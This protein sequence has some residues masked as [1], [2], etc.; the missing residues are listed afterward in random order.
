MN[1]A[2]FRQQ[3][4][5][6]DSVPDAEL[7]GALYEKF[8]AGKLPRDDFDAQ[9]L[10]AS[11]PASDPQP[12]PQQ[13]EPDTFLSRSADGLKRMYGDLVGDNPGQDFVT[14]LKAAVSG[15]PFVGQYVD[16]AYAAARSAVTG[17]DEKQVR[18]A[19]NAPVEQM[20]PYARAGS[21]VAGGLATPM[22]PGVGGAITS[23]AT[24]P[25]WTVPVIAAIESIF[26]GPGRRD[27]G[28]P[29]AQD[30]AEN[31]IPD[32]V[33]GATGGVG[34]LALSEVMG[35]TI[36]A[37]ANAFRAARGKPVDPFVGKGA[38]QAHSRM[39]AAVEANDPVLT[40]R[41]LLEQ[42]A[43]AS[44][45]KEVFG[46]GGP[47]AKQVSD[48][49][50]AVMKDNTRTQ[51][52]GAAFQDLG[53]VPVGKL[54]TPDEIASSARITSNTLLSRLDHPDVKKIAEGVRRDVRF[55]GISDDNATFV[56]EVITRLSEK[57]KGLR[58]ENPVKSKNAESIYARLVEDM[59]A[60][61]P[62]YKGA[63]QGYAEAVGET[64][65]A[66]EAAKAAGG[67]AKFVKS[68]ASVRAPNLG[69]NVSGSV[70]G[71]MTRAAF[72][73]SS[74]LAEKLG[75]SSTKEANKIIARLLAE[76]DPDQIAMMVR[77]LGE[78]RA[79]MR[80]RPSLVFQ[81]NNAMTP[82]RT[83]ETR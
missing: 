16:N 14:G 2:E 61:L 57:A 76:K 33:I 3:Y 23:L 30:V 19:Y 56:H 59:E 75:L 42:P 66:R 11:T 36:P 52:A 83:E 73:Y 62:G 26:S 27:S 54:T 9:F 41:P 45:G 43:G 58:K 35:R 4:P 34:G 70:P 74:L 12:A 37:V 63:R 77:M 53:I 69:E 20:N 10:G 78:K 24:K 68:E 17:E 49:A 79:G 6:Y 81:G 50:K 38:S 31:I 21:M 7:A 80:S 44:L 39:K 25:A 47:T 65:A 28:K 82:W 72:N 71:A 48:A 22:I 40:D 29:L 46:H 5:Q 8:Y 51:A 13:P 55:E 1:I 18:D 32:A 15:V 67:N 60:A 64:A